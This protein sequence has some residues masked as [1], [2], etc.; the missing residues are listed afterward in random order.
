[1]DGE[2]VS[3]GDGEFVVVVGKQHA[4]QAARVNFEIGAGETVFDGDFPQAGS[5]ENS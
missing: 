5:T 3:A 4:P 1:V 2:G